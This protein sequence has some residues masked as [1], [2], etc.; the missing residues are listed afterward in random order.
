M[1]LEIRVKREYSYRPTEGKFRGRLVVYLPAVDEDSFSLNPI[2]FSPKTFIGYKLRSSWGDR[3]DKKGWRFTSMIL[4]NESIYE[5][6][7]EM[8]IKEKELIEFLNK[9]VKENKL[10]QEQVPAST[11]NI[12]IIVI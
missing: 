9:I 11:E 4:E 1:K 3:N 8:E 7:E 2:F 5:L 12:Y 6:E 10:R